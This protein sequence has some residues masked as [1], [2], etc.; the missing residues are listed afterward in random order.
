MHRKVMLKLCLSNSIIN[1][2]LSIVYYMLFTYYYHNLVFQFFIKSIKK[3]KKLY[4]YKRIY[5][6]SLMIGK[7]SI[8]RQ[9]EPYHVYLCSNR[10]EKKFVIK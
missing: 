5:I 4:G 9:F 7:Y 10:R 2:L 3:T 6:L 8:I 1:Y